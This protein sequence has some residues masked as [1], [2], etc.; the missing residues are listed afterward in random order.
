MATGNWFSF[1]VFAEERTSH[2]SNWLVRNKTYGLMVPTGALVDIY[3]NTNEEATI[4]LQ[5]QTA[6][7]P[8]LTAVQ[9]Y[10]GTN[11]GIAGGV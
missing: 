10:D 7:P 4:V 8:T 5:H 11:V 1:D 2:S 6:A 9:L 3:G